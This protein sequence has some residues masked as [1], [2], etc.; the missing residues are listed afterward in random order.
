MH[1][2]LYKDG[3][4][5]KLGDVKTTPLDL[6]TLGL[7]TSNFCFS[8]NAL[9]HM[10]LERLLLFWFD[11][12][13]ETTTIIFIWE[14]YWK[15]GLN[16][17]GCY[18]NDWEKGYLSLF[19]MTHIVA[20]FMSFFMSNNLQMLYHELSFIHVLMLYFLSPCLTWIS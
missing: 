20:W 17:F 8:I 11:F 14:S 12:C 6:H 3:E 7:R 18:Y 15:F 16:L 9:F 19:L 2:E 5:H 10:N 4:S 1:H 13:F